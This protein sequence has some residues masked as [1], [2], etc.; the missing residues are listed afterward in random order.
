MNKYFATFFYDEEEQKFQEKSQEK[1]KTILNTYDE[2]YNEL[3]P[4]EADNIANESIR[5][6][7]ENTIETI[8]LQKEYFETNPSTYKF[9][10]VWILNIYLREIQVEGLPNKITKIEENV[11]FARSFFRYLFR[12]NLKPKTPI[13]LEV[14]IQSVYIPAFETMWAGY[15]AGRKIGGRAW[16]GGGNIN[17]EEEEIALAQ[18]PTLALAQTPTIAPATRSRKRA[19]IQG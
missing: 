16:G 11:E 18:T 8:N 2:T 13:E 5:K 10:Y 14:R 12:D 19:R 6:K 17:E 3:A 7:I 15:V 1:S 4:G 9:P